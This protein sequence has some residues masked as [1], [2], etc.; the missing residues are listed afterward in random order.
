M[1]FHDLSQPDFEKELLP[2]L[3][4]VKIGSPYSW[5]FLDQELTHLES[6]EV[7][8]SK[9]KSKTKPGK[10]V[11]RSIQARLYWH[12]YARGRDGRRTSVLEDMAHIRNLQDANMGTPS[13]EGKW[14]IL[15]VESDGRLLVKNGMRYRRVFPGQYVVSE[16]I[17]GPP[18]V[19]TLLTLQIPTESMRFQNGYYYTMGEHLSDQNEDFFLTR[20]YFNVD[21]ED[22]PTL[23]RE[24]TTQLN[25][26]Q[27]PFRLKLPSKPGSYGRADAAVLYI[28]RRDY[29]I[30]AQLLNDLFIKLKSILAKEIPMFC[31]ILAPGVGLAEGPKGG[32][33]FGMNRIR[34]V[35][36][37]LYDAYESGE[38]SLDGR[39]SHVRKRFESN[40]LDWDRPYLNPN[41]MDCYHASFSGGL[42]L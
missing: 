17:I 5:S 6:A 39:L 37:G 8:V 9:K 36:K 21:A 3:E 27:V 7:N 25:H 13:W 22:A 40:G 42:A 32:E 26:F 30:T 18:T 41:S 10:A 23:V 2:V 20:L 28:A 19:H 15:R 16:P 11:I 14:K 35:A 1:T 24:L 31:K 4:A 33:S 38:T 34:L 29:S 12:Y